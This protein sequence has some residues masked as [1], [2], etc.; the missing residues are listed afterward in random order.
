MLAIIQVV[1]LFYIFFFYDMME[2]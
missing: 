1:I 2:F